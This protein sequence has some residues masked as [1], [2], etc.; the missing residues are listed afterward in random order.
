MPEPTQK[1][2]H[3]AVQIIGNR[4]SNVSQGELEIQNWDKS[5][6]LGRSLKWT[7]ILWGGA[8]ISVLIPIL[9]FLLVPSF[10]I[11]GPIVG[12]LTYKT[13][14]AVLGGKGSCPFCKAPLEIAKTAYEFPVKELCT[15]CYSSLA[16]QPM[17]MAQSS[18]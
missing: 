2:A 15:E 13:E 18:H 10:F 9:H 3:I 8:L 4:N 12:W 1:I 7:A 5:D 6:R 14:K 11:A 16:I 17:P